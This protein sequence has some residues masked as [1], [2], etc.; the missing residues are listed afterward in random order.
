MRLHCIPDSCRAD[1]QEARAVAAVFLRE[2]RADVAA[3][4]RERVAGA[5]LAAEWF[6]IIAVT[7]ALAY[8][9][10]RGPLRLL[11]VPWALYAGFAL[12]VI[13]HY[14]NH[15]PVFRS[16]WANRLWRW[17]G[18]LVFFNPLEI[19]RVH[20]EHH[21]AYSDP[22]NEERPFGPEDRGKSFWAC[23][24]RE[25][26]ESVLVLVPFRAMPACVAALAKK[27]PAE[28]R[29]IV[30][31]RW[32][33]LAWAA[34]LTAIDP[35]DTLLSFLPAVVV[36]GSLASLI[37]NYTDHIPGDAHHPFRLATYLEPETRAEALFAAMNHHTAATHLTHHLFPSA[38][39]VH[40]PALQRRLAPIYAR[41]GAPR[42]LLVNSALAGDPVRLGR[43]LVGIERRRFDLA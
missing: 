31:M 20:H 5:L 30:A 12:D 25:A 29:E 15:W 33:F 22:E 21:R 10:P 36:V 4:R 35:G 18:V 28:H 7:Y 23:L 17:S 13:V 24:L 42:S 2:R 34:V 38:H 9:L 39:W 3:Q 16:A 27:N 6:G 40:L 1:Y 32:A 37:M 14:T 8:G 43:V 19:E 11:L 41:Q 26:A